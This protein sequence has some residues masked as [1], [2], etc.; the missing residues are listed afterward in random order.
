[1]NINELDL[2]EEEDEGGIFFFW[3]YGFAGIAYGLAG[4]ACFVTGIGAAGAT[5]VVLT[6]KLAGAELELTELLLAADT[7]EEVDLR[8]PLK[9]N[10]GTLDIVS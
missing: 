8:L 5:L 2:D 6:L 4:G 10:F 7:D 3:Q 1:M 9:L